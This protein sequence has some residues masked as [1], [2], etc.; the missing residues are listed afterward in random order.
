MTSPEKTIYDV[1]I[2]G[3]PL[4]LKTSN[5][6]EKVDEII[7]LVNSEVQAALKVSQSGSLQNA[8]IVAALN[9]AEELIRKRE[10][11]KKELGQLQA[12]AE[13]LVEDLAP[14]TQMDH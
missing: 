2:A 12:D 8:A 13:A 10:S 3:V 11:V 5:S 4:K 7:S 6:P 9:I 14:F 1:E